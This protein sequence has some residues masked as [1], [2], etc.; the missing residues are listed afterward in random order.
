MQ[1]TSIIFIVD[2]FFYVPEVFILN[3]VKVVT[4]STADLTKELINKYNIGVISLHV[5]LDGKEYLDEELDPD[6]LYATARE[7]GKLPTT[8]AITPM[9][10]K[11]F[12]TPYIER[13]YDI[14]YVG[15]SSALSSSVQNA[16]VAAGEIGQDRVYVV[17]SLNLSTGIGLLVL[18]A[19]EFAASGMDAKTVYEK[20]L[21]IV[22]RVKV[23][24]VID[25][26]EFLCM[27]GRCTSLEKWA[28]T[29]FKIHPR[30]IVTSEGTMTVGEKFKGKRE[31]V[32]NGLLESTLLKKDRIDPHRIFV[33]HSGCPKE[34][35]DYLTRKLKEAIP[36]AEEV[37]VTRAG[38]TISSHCGPKTVGILYIEK[39]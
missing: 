6:F 5:M 26:L 21:E 12:F 3:P 20:L 30:I 11:E 35:L 39:P 15:L 29:L 31:I 14:I 27:G 8:A 34:E 38:C 7:K 18:Q 22:P 16:K 32:I 10:Y 17:D 19:A 2:L 1:S 23:S 28:G 37:L 4:D 24:F 33:T 25:T 13:G 36:D 9:E